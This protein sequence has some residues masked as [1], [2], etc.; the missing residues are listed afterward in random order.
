MNASYQRDK[1]YRKVRNIIIKRDQARCVDCGWLESSSDAK[2]LHVH[3]IIPERL[4]SD[5]ANPH[6]PENLVT[7][8]SMC[9][10]AWEKEFRAMLKSRPAWD[11]AVRNRIRKHLDADIEFLEEHFEEAH[12]MALEAVCEEADDD[13]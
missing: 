12:E 6:Q 7:L 4:F 5:K 9:H 8:C 1:K 11:E 13:D 2:Q 3:H 10:G